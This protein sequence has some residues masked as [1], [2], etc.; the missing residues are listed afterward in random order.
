[1]DISIL[2]EGLKG[3]YAFQY[4][5][6]R[7]SMTHASS[8]K[9]LVNLWNCSS[10][11]CVTFNSVSFIYIYSETFISINGVAD[12]VLH[13]VYIQQI[14]FVDVNDKTATYVWCIVRYYNSCMVWYLNCFFLS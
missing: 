2:I 14:C 6:F 10:A 9:P 1:M 7:L 12:Q 5:S 13:C 4:A 11:D 8:V 3:V